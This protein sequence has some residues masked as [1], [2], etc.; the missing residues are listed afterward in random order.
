M[1]VDNQAGSSRSEPQA[2]G[3]GTNPIARPYKRK[4]VDEYGN[5]VP[6]S[7]RNRAVPDNQ[8]KMDVFKLILHWHE[9]LRACFRIARRDNLDDIADIT[10]IVETIHTKFRQDMNGVGAMKDKITDDFELTAAGKVITFGEVRA[11]MKLLATEYGFKYQNSDADKKE[12]INVSD[13]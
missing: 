2:S 10:A 12:T 8:L 3:S 5:E 4:V 1:E 9:Y 7:K 13:H 11:H 6:D